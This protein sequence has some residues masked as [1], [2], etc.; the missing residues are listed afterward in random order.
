MVLCNNLFPP[1]VA[2]ED[3]PSRQVGF[4]TLSFGYPAQPQV[5]Y[6]IVAAQGF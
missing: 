2:Q 6:P 4:I 5:I 3:H 1:N